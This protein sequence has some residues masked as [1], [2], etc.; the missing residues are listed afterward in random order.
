MLLTLRAEKQQL[1]DKIEKLE[2]SKTRVERI[3]KQSM[4]NKSSLRKTGGNEP[5][6][7]YEELGVLMKRIEFLE[8]QSEEREKMTYM[9]HG[10]CKREI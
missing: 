7:L 6:D 8:Q 3:L 9:E 5:D 2:A 4:G 1:M 10:P